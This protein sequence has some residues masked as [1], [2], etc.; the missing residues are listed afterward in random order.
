MRIQKQGA[1]VGYVLWVL[2]KTAWLT[3]IPPAGSEKDFWRKKQEVIEEALKTMDELRP[4]FFSKETISAVEQG[5]NSLKLVPQN[6]V[7]YDSIFASDQTVLD[8]KKGRKPE[9]RINESIVLLSEHF[10]EAVGGPRPRTVAELMNAF[11][12]GGYHSAYFEK[13]KIEQRFRRFRFPDRRTLYLN[14]YS[15][16]QMQSLTIS[17]VFA[18]TQNVLSRSKRRC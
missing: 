16:Y 8:S 10:K 5:L 11:S 9:D 13:A 3:R 2:L 1:D 6:H 14:D 12:I 7:I 17:S 18:P 4:Y 15:T